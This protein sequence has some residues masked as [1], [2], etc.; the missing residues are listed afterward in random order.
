MDLTKLAFIEKELIPL[1]KTLSV[2]A[3]RK[4]GKMNPQQMVEHLSNFFRVS[5]N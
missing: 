4:W 5:T 1:L 2:N 3:N